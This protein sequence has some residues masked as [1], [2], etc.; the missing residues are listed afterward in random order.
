MAI[1][2]KLGLSQQDRDR[3]K[4]LHLAHLAVTEKIDLSQQDKARLPTDLLFALC[5]QGVVGLSE[6]QMAC[7]SA[8]QLEYPKERETA[9]SQIGCKL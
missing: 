1:T 6:R 9:H 3:L 8:A 7:Y 4:P 5:V 2:N